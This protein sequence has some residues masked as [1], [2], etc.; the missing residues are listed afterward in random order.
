MHKKQKNT[1]NQKIN[2][3]LLCPIS[4]FVEITGIQVN[5]YYLF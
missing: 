5:T 1:E 4:R 2:S 3:I